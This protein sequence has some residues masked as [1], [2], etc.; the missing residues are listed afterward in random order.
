[1]SLRTGRAAWGRR[2][3]RWRL[4]PLV[5]AMLA[6]IFSAQAQERFE[7][8][9][10]G[11]PAL[12]PTARIEGESYCPLTTLVEKTD[13]DFQWDPVLQRFELLRN[14]EVQVAGLVDS[15]LYWVKGE[16]VYRRLEP[17]FHEGGL[18]LPLVVLREV[19]A[20]ALGIQFRS[21]PP[22]PATLAPTSTPRS[23][24]TPRPKSTPLLPPVIR[25]PENLFETPMAIPEL[26]PDRPEESPQTVIVID[27]ARGGDTDPG[28]IGPEGHREGDLLFELA[29]LLKRRLEDSLP[30]KVVLTREKSPEHRIIAEERAIRANSARGTLLLSLHLGG[31]F[32]E[33]SEGFSVF[34]MTEIADDREPHRFDSEGRPLGDWTLETGSDWQTAYLPFQMKSGKLAKL[35]HKSLARQ[36]P[37]PDRGLRAARITLLRSAA[38]PGVWVELGVFTNSREALRL[39]RSDHQEKIVEALFLALREYLDGE[40]LTQPAQ[41][42][43][44]RGGRL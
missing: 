18:Y 5:A 42:P 15:P 12:L 31:G 38:M 22:A 44:N 20:P 35:I 10:E 27:P 17:R 34:Y 33:I 3:V 37:A 8:E 40:G 26:L 9:T 19:L 32:Q 6:M 2:R 29:V 4:S 28:A 16:M 14:G 7:V 25:L 21:A 43:D 30:V 23:T 41:P 39:T 36:L 13:L 11:G 1:M 24:P